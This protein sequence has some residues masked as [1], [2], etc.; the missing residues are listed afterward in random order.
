MKLFENIYQILRPKRESSV[1][2]VHGLVNASD[3]S[4]TERFIH[5]KETLLSVSKD[6]EQEFVSFGKE[7]GALF[8]EA[9]AI[10]AKVNEVLEV[11]TGDSTREAV[12]LFELLITDTEQMIARDQEE[13]DSLV[14]EMTVLKGEIETLFQHRMMID[15]A[16]RH[17]LALL[18][19]GFRVEGASRMQAITKVLD[20]VGV[21]VANLGKKVV[22]GT[23][24]QFATLQTAVNSMKGLIL[25]LHGMSIDA[26]REQGETALK[27]RKL[28]QHVQQLRSARLEQDQV[29]QEI[30]AIG[31]ELHRE[32][33]RVVM[34]LQYHDI[35]RQQLEHVAE[36][37]ES[38]IPAAVRS[39]SSLD[40]AALLHQTVKVQV[41]QTQAALGSL[42]MAGLEFQQGMNQI[43]ERVNDLE[44]KVMH[45]QSLC[46]ND[47]LFMT[48]RSLESL[49]SMIDVRN[50]LKRSVG[51][52]ACQIFGKVTDSS[53]ILTELT[54]DLRILAINAQVQAANA[55]HHEVVEMLAKEMCE[56][57]GSIKSGAEALTRDMQ[58][59]MKKLADLAARAW[60]LGGQQSEEGQTLHAEVPKC[61]NLLTGLQEKV[62]DGLAESE[63]LQVDLQSRISRLLSKVNFPLVA[64][65][66]LLTVLRFFRE[67]EVETQPK[68]EHSEASRQALAN[69][70]TNYTMASEREVHAIA[71]AESGLS[72]AEVDLF[73]ESGSS[74][75]E[76]KHE[77]SK[78]DDLGD[79]IELF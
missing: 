32:F 54:L 63:A 57:S 1:L 7:S 39:D 47:E 29:G 38:R 15:D 3:S 46:K 78:G 76:V 13:V 48:L 45:F 55:E 65:D 43:V 17:P 31:K 75:S 53:A 71:V 23:Y 24:E 16:A 36:A 30:A 10:L 73:E 12:D 6:T 52:T 58:T 70:E 37:F 41:H 4:L 59:I 69:M 21:E 67:V 9:K 35:T 77:A 50:K 56:V 62:T 19:I 74:T 68:G 28:K 40:S 51:E 42:K 60:E 25:S 33:N 20:A 79:N 22:A 49:Q 44:T 34:A 8:T 26:R 2:A 27:I 66:R 72:K 18:K 11:A 14:S 5:Q 61:I 64:S